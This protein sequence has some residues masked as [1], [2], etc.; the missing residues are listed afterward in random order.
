MG[1]SVEWVAIENSNHS[2]N[3][4]IDYKELKNP[5]E[6]R[7]QLNKKIGDFEVKEIKISDNKI[8]IHLMNSMERI[9]EVYPTQ[10]VKYTYSPKKSSIEFSLS[11]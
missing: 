5:N 9:V 7:Y 8:E 2:K 6:L 10:N 3:L 11:D 4:G 1:L